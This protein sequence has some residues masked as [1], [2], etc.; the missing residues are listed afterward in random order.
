M[1]IL[2][3]QLYTR[4]AAGCDQGKFILLLNEDLCQSNQNNFCTVWEMK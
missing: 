1:E 2:F 3:S 4:L